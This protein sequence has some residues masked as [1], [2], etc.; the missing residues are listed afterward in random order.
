MATGLEMKL[1]VGDAG[2]AIGALDEV[3]NCRDVNING[4]TGTADGSVRGKKY[5]VN[6]TTLGELTLDIEMKYVPGDDEYELMRDA[7]LDKEPI[8][9]AALSGPNDESGSEGPYG[10]WIITSFGRP[11]PLEDIVV[12]NITAELHDYEGDD[13]W[14][15]VGGS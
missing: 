1:Y 10:D 8:A 2:T 9:L 3:E 4:T 14:T 15:E 5:R 6:E 7:W 12:V 11:E 13:P